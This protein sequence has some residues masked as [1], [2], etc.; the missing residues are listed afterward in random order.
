M[1]NLQLIDKSKLWPGVKLEP[2]EKIYYGRYP[3]KVNMV[4]PLHKKFVSTD[5]WEEYSAELRSRRLQL[6]NYA[7]DVDEYCVNL[8]TAG[9]RTY[10]TEKVQRVYIRTYQDFICFSKFYQAYNTSVS[11]PL[12]QEHLDILLS[13]D[14]YFANREKPYFKKF[15]CIMEVVPPWGYGNHTDRRKILEEAREFISSSLDANKIKLGRSGYYSAKSYINY[16]DYEDLVPFVK[17][18]FPECNIRLT[19]C[20]LPSLEN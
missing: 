16:D 17:L 3:Y 7:N 19:R 8:F 13:S 1:K 15:N 14:T 9:W 11:G 5:N 18:S 10:F 2:S 4:F 20:C 6:W 12:S